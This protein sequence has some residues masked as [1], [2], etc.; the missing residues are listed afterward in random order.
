L[1]HEILQ[2]LIKGLKSVFKANKKY[3]SS[4]QS[5]AARSIKQ[6]T[7][8]KQETGILGWLRRR[9]EQDLKEREESREEA[10]KSERV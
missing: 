5:S 2:D 10:A 4:S 9:K 6:V 8:E 1:K 3:G 7:P